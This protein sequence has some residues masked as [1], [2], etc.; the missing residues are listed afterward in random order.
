M[1]KRPIIV[2][3]IREERAK[4]KTYRQV[5]EALGVSFSTVQRVCKRHGI[6]AKELRGGYR[7]R[8]PKR[9]DPRGK[10]REKLPPIDPE[11]ARQITEAKKRYWR[12]SA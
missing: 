6:R 9:P 8:R 11:R 4:D 7:P 1:K 5:A 3:L 12:Q 2:E 10:L